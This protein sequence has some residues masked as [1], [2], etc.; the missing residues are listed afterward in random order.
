[1]LYSGEERL[2]TYLQDRLFTYL[3]VSFQKF[4]RK[5]PVRELLPAQPIEEVS[6]DPWWIAHIGYITEDDVKVGVNVCVF[7]CMCAHP[8]VCAT[9]CVCACVYMYAYAHAC[10]CV[11]CVNVH[12]L[13]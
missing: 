8:I 13:V 4:F 7:V 2:F 12:L 3:P 6:I 5:R 1:M 10:M 9:V 11:L